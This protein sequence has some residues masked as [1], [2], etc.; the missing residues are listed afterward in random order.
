VDKLQFEAVHEKQRGADSNKQSN[1]SDT[2]NMTN[3]NNVIVYVFNVQYVAPL[4]EKIYERE[5][6][7]TTVHF[8]DP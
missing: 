1:V 7:E 3:I 2:I 4:G 6:Y 5:T 8:I